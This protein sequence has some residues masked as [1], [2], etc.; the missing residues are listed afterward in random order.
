MCIFS[1][2]GRSK[3][4]WG[5]TS[6][7]DVPATPVVWNVLQMI[8]QFGNALEIILDPPD[9][10]VGIGEVMANKV[11]RP[12]QLKDVPD[13]SDPNNQ[14]IAE[15]VLFVELRQSIFTNPTIHMAS[16]TSKICSHDKPWA[17]K[18]DPSGVGSIE[19]HTGGLIIR[20]IRPIT[21]TTP[22]KT[23]SRPTRR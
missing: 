11:P 1:L 17:V 14:G 3:F 5:N 9:C 21:Y 7:Q 23:T 19:W 10:Q 18:Y 6:P 15:N 4:K 2:S 20:I 12:D 16:G 8:S 13:F 22:H